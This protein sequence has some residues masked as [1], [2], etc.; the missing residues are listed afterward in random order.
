MKK[1]TLYLLLFIGSWS[2]VGTDEITIDKPQID[3]NAKIVVSP[4]T[5]GVLIGDN[6][7][8]TAVYTNEQ[9]EVE[10]VGFEWISSDETVA[11]VSADGIASGVTEGSIIITAKYAGIESNQ[12]TFNVVTSAS[13]VSTINVTGSVSMLFLGE[14][15]TLSA[16]AFDLNSN[17]LPTVNFTW[18]SMDESLATIDV[19]GKVTAS[20]TKEG[21]ASFYAISDGKMS[22]VYTIELFDPTNV[23]IRNSVFQGSGGYSVSGTVSLEQESN[24]QLTLKFG[25]DFMS[26]QGP[27]LVVYLSN[28]T[29][30]VIG[31]GVE[32]KP[33]P[34]NSGAFEIDVTAINSSIDITD[35]EFVMIHCKPFNVPFG[36]AMLG[37]VQ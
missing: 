32:L 6:K 25:D 5:Q 24:G 15:T 17:E 29:T 28:S 18:K 27:G 30:N 33:L 10:D 8:F 21:I 3:V 7:T 14:S 34:Q 11:T 31:Q 12:A 2:C 35:Y 23:L 9:G 16:K 19:N 37:S 22:N 1:Y 26:A 20:V 36:N 4:A 13:S